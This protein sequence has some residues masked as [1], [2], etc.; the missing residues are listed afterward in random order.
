M[1]YICN[2]QR[3]KNGSYDNILSY[4][5]FIPLKDRRLLLISHFLQKII[6]GGYDCPDLLFSINFKINSFNSR[7]PISFYPKYSDKNYMLNPPANLL[8]ITG[9]TYTFDYI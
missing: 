9:N 8:M 5:N 2:I 7:N 6:S 1:S 4:L 3:P